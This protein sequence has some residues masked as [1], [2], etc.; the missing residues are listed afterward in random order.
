MFEAELETAVTAARAAGALLL[1][2]REQGFDVRRKLDRSLV[3]SADLA[4]EEQILS[5][6]NAEFSADGI[7]SE[8]AGERG[9]GG[10]RCWIVDPLDGTSNYSLGLPFFAVSIALWEDTRP[11]V[12]VVYLPV[13]D[14]LFTATGDSVATLNGR[15]IAVS[16]TALVLAAA[17]NVYFDRHGCLEAGLDVFRRVAI[18]CEGRVKVL[19]STASLLCYVACGRLDASVKNRTRVW[20]FA[21]GKLILE[22]A[23]GV[24]TD[25]AGTPLTASGQSL[26][27][28]NGRVHAELAGVIGG[29]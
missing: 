25:F 26:L 9:G 1:E 3:T 23:G 17:I 24:L 6:L 14:E 16:D 22:R 12:G 7:L 19:G 28:T 4:S 18:Q 27:A 21:A 5:R 13:L 2:H 20:D 29:E 10:G 11:L 15:P 8:E